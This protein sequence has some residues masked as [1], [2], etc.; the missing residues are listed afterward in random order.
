MQRLMPSGLTSARSNVGSSEVT[1]ETCSQQRVTATWLTAHELDVR[2]GAETSQ[3]L[4]VSPLVEK[5]DHPQAPGVIQYRILDDMLSS[6]NSRGD[7]YSLVSEQ[8]LGSTD[9]DTARSWLQ[10]GSEATCSL[11][12]VGDCP[13]ITLMPKSERGLTLSARAKPKANVKRDRPEASAKRS[14]L[15]PSNEIV[16]AKILDQLH[17][18]V[19]KKS[20]RGPLEGMVTPRFAECSAIAVKE[21]ITDEDLSRL[22]ELQGQL[23]D[24]LGKK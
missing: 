13:T 7:K 3:R 21:D 2:F 4:T 12:D 11:P 17:K 24:L 15:A 19:D 20:P 5:R 10:S 1:K 8:A 23:H 6:S 9:A 14:K 16:A 18:L 22:R